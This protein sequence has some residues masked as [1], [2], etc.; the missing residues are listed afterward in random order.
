MLCIQD[1]RKGVV[2]VSLVEQ[3]VLMLSCVI[4]FS[5]GSIHAA[6][7][8]WTREA[9]LA[10]TSNRLTAENRSNIFHLSPLE[11]QAAIE[12]GSE[13]AL[14][15]P[16]NETLTIPVAS[17]DALYQGSAAKMRV[18][19][20]LSPF[21]SYDEM[22]DWLGLHDFPEDR[23][24]IS[25]N[26]IPPPSTRRTRRM[27]VTIVEK[28]GGFGLT[29]GCAT[30]HSSNLF[31]VKVLGMTNRFPRANE[32]FIL[33]K[34]ALSNTSIGT[35]QTLFDPSPGD[36]RQFSD[37]KAA[38]TRLDAVKPLAVGLDTS[39]AQV[40]RSLMLRQGT[41]LPA[42][43]A[44]ADAKPSVWW[45]MKYKTRWLS[46]G[47]M[48]A[49]NPIHT[50]ILWN[51]LGRGGD[52]AALQDWFTDS[53]TVANLRD[54]TAY[55]FATKAPLYDDFFP[56]SIDVA[57]ARRGEVLFNRNCSRCHGRYKKGW[58]RGESTYRER[59][60]TT[61]VLYFPRTPVVDVGTD[62][63]RWRG[64]TSLAPRLNNLSLSKVLEVTVESQK[65][66][67]PPPLV[68]IWARWPY[69]HNNSVPTLFDVLTVEEKRPTTYFA[70]PALDP[71]TDFDCSKVGYPTGNAVPASWRRNRWQAFDT[72]VTGLGNSGHSRNILRLP[73]GT[74][75]YNATEK[76]DI[77]EFLKTL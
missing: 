66:Y 46:D 14:A 16:Y 19:R 56:H 62:P 45:T 29:F 52:I 9:S 5:S 77:I 42:N 61:D 73:D 39:V 58:S 43:P 51:E 7:P 72:R 55:V 23:Q 68:G 67:V 60:A 15:Y 33:S 57:R 30:C 36:V 65:G 47:S 22:Y 13:H 37:A 27:G 53:G 48:V 8:N 74:E 1:C 64:M 4:L 41:A 59:I 11:L 34:A 70:G 17:L 75:R 69:F 3:C 10:M 31:G 76:R 49:G 25:P 24:P 20:S 6:S 44:P 2:N 71:K 28:H 54:L 50:N 35:F 32:F 12:R 38:L 18:S 26:Y 21:R 63:H 40:Q